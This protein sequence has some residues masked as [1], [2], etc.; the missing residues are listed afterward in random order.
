MAGVRRLGRKNRVEDVMGGFKGSDGKFR[1]QKFFLLMKFSL[2]PVLQDLAWMLS[3][4]IRFFLTYFPFL[5]VKGTLGLH[6]LVRYHPAHNSNIF[7]AQFVS[8]LCV[9]FSPAPW[10]FFSS[11]PVL[12]PDP[13]S[14]TGWFPVRLQ[15]VKVCV[16]LI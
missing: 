12:S 11:L 2:S 9:S 14:G 4:Y 13:F 1:S 5:G 15:E 7:S 16:G 3:F 10:L 8:I 6:L